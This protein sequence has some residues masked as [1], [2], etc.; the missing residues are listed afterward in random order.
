MR[1]PG[2]R[3][4]RGRRLSL[5]RALALT[6]YTLVAG[7]CGASTA[8]APAVGGSAPRFLGYL[9]TGLTVAFD[10]G[11]R[12]AAVAAL[13]P[14]AVGLPST[15][16]TNELGW[17]EGALRFAARIVDIAVDDQGGLALDSEGR[18]VGWGLAVGGRGVAPVLAGERAT[19]VAATGGRY[20]VLSRSGAVHCASAERDPIAMAM[21]D[22]RALAAGARRLCVVRGEED[23]LRCWDIDQL[24]SGGERVAR[25][26]SLLAGSAYG[27]CYVH[28]DADRVDC[29][30]LASPAS[31]LDG[32]TSLGVGEQHACAVA[33]GHLWCWGSAVTSGGW[34]ALGPRGFDP[35]TVPADAPLLVRVPAP[36]PVL[37]VSPGATVAL[38]GW[39]TCVTDSGTE[40]CDGPGPPSAPRDPFGNLRLA[41]G[42]RPYHEATRGR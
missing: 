24:E 31:P 38:H 41:F 21:R 19:D 3:I 34:L 22:V 2:R 12:R 6:C 28:G 25:G 27:V 1:R 20:C 32:V 9:G 4:H 17:N 29:A 39:M 7:A 11:R 10:R 14:E 26:V 40:R 15:A 36:R 18:V 35:D 42:R 13:R 33:R 30:G 8:N 16:P 5:R 23:E 37:E